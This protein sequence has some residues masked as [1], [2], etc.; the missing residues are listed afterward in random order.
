MN[1]DF[2]TAKLAAEK[3]FLDG[4]RF[5][6]EDCKLTNN[7]GA[8]Y[9]NGSHPDILEAPDLEQVKKWLREEH[10]SILEIT[11]HGD[12]TDGDFNSKEDFRWEYELNYYGKHFDAIQDGECDATEAYFFSYEGA[13]EAGVIK[14]L[15]LL[16]V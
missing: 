15:E 5:I 2:K 13:L 9:I 14:A 6:Y 4:S 3:G 1:V 10:N 12:G 11:M 7:L 16:R 8:V